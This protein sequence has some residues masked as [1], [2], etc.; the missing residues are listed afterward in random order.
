MRNFAKNGLWSY[1]AEPL[2]YRTGKRFVVSDKTGVEEAVAEINYRG[3]QRHKLPLEYILTM[4]SQS[5]NAFCITRCPLEAYNTVQA[6]FQAT[7]K[8]VKIAKFKIVKNIQLKM[9]K[10][11]VEY[12][13]KI[14]N[15]PGLQESV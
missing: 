4:T 8:A 11:F 5:Y 6:M 3:T 10:A 15:I 12:F 2:I 13:K 9:V 1:V 14:V 7:A